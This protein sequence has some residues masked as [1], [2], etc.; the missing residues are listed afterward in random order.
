MVE[1]GVINS[2]GNWINKHGHTPSPELPEA[3]ME[4]IK[5]KNSIWYFDDYFEFLYKKEKEIPESIKHFLS[6]PKRYLFNTQE[7]L[8][9]AIL[10]EFNSVYQKIKINCL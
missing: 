2:D 6:D 5:K 1:V 8:H 4:K 10:T 3:V 9:D 7:T